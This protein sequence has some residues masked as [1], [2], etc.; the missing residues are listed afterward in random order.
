MTHQANNP[1]YPFK[2][3]I[4]DLGRI[5]YSDAQVVQERSRDE[6]AE[7][8]RKISSTGFQPVRNRNSV[9]P[10]SMHL[11]LLEHDPPVITISKRPGA[12]EHIT[13]QPERL[14]ELGIEVQQTDRGGDVTY[15]GPGQLVAYAVLDLRRLGLGL[16]DY[17]RLLEVVVIRTVASWG[18]VGQRDPKATG[19][20]V[21]RIGSGGTAQAESS[22]P[23]PCLAPLQHITALPQEA[24]AKICAMG[25]RVSRWI[26][27][28][29]LAL[30]VTTDLTHFQTIVPCG[31]VGRPVTSMAE[32]IAPKIQVTIKDVKKKLGEEFRVALQ[33]PKSYTSM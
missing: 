22:E 2:L 31:L 4:T 13:S 14:N 10:I 23:D 16:R 32:E 25:V 5:S 7:A 28:H 24:S 8:V 20:W 26:T 27:T 6:L 12:A 11:F 30:N 19:V 15:H 18:I 33:N 1:D 29:G 9:E 17:M 3:S 21:P